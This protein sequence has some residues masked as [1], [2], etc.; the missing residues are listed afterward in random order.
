MDDK[1]I[2][3][4]R[5]IIEL[6]YNKSNDSKIS[7]YLTLNNILDSYYSKTAISRKNAII[8]EF[9]LNGGLEDEF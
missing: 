4:F 2:I 1:T 3:F 6:A 5:K 7:F 8:K 9:N